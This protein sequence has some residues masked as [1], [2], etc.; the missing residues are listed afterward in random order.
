VGDRDRDAALRGAV[1]LGQDDAAH[2]HGLAEEPR[3]LQ[4]VLPGARVDDEE[5][6]V[7]RAFEPLG[8]HSPHLR[9]LFHQVRLSVQSA[10]G[11]GRRPHRGRATSRR[12]SRRRP[13]PQGRRPS[14]SP[15]SRRLRAPP[16]LQLLLGRGAERADRYP[17][18]SNER[19]KRAN[20]R[21]RASS[22][23]CPPVSAANAASARS[24]T[25]FP[26]PTASGMTAPRRRAR[27]RRPRHPRAA[28]PCAAAR[29]QRQTAPP[30]AK[31]ARWRASS[32]AADRH[33]PAPAPRSFRQAPRAGTR[34]G[35]SPVAGMPLPA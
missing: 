6:L 16:D 20:C 22:T 33:A 35:T 27:A 4:A 14:P 12:R 15:R 17:R 25:A 26:A 24:L 5:R 2:V 3:L 30:R 18:S 19:R 7:R 13:P 31:G 21:S 8:D 10:G 32:G 23:R 29:G 11:V 34:T 9:E 1:E 28:P